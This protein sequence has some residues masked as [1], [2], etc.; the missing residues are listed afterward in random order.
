MSDISETALLLF[1]QGRKTKSTPSGWI[2]GNAPCCHNRG[3]TRDTKS[4]GGLLMTTTGGFNYHCFNCNFKA[5][6]APGHLLSK[7]TK[8]LFRWLGMPDEEIDKLYFYTIKN[9]S[10]QIKEDKV[11]NFNLNE[12][13]LPENT[14]SIEQW[15]KENCQDPQLLEIIKY[16]IDERKLNWD[17]YPWHWSIENGYRDRVIIPFYHDNKIVG[18]TGRKITE[19]KPKYLTHA[20]PGYVFN[21]D[22]QIY[23]RDY[24]IV[25]EGQF[26]AIAIDG[27]AI[28]HNEPNEVQCIRI[29][30]LGKQVIVVPDRDKAGIT[31]IN[32]ALNNNWTVSM[33]PWEDDIKDVADAVKRYGR[34]YTL[35]SIL[36]HKETNELKIQ[37]M[38]KKLEN[39]HAKI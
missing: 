32:A 23:S 10:D 12:T 34:L 35:T 21:I 7:N 26:D 28:M 20:Q 16:I 4:R 6:W 30:R 2:A 13:T 14:K 15:S 1:T 19:G 8:N 24:V 11:L 33:P 37:L 22:K 36:T 18:W 29:N 3:E 5:G 27:V 38:K 31:M 39:I 17:W 25:V 9:K